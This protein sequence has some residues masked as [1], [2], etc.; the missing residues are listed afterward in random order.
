M[1]FFRVAILEG[2]IQ[3][4]RDVLDFHGTKAA[5]LTHWNRK[6]KLVSTCHGT[7]GWLS[8]FFARYVEIVGLGFGPG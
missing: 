7:V 2:V 6:E 1:F 5:L 8:F 4:R 3:K